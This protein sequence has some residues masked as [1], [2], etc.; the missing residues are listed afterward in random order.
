MIHGSKLFFEII[1]PNTKPV[2]HPNSNIIPGKLAS[3]TR[4]PGVLFGLV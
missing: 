3:A 2:I 1:L 4:N